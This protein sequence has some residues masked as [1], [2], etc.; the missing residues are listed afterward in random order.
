MQRIPNFTSKRGKK[1]KRKIEELTEM[2][3]SELFPNHVF[4]EE[5]LGQ[6]KTIQ[7]T[8]DIPIHLLENAG[9]VRQLT[10]PPDEELMQKENENERSHKNLEEALSTLTERQRKILHERFFSGK[11]LKK[12][13][14]ELGISSKRVDDI[15]RKALRRLRNPMRMRLIQGEIRISDPLFQNWLKEFDSKR[16]MA[17]FEK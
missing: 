16:P 14:C 9:M 12:I 11:T 10:L 15:E 1:I 13:A 4:T 2:T 3:V 7:V 8:K 17:K 5:F 6:D